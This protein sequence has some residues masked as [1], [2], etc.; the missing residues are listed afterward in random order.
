M[1]LT[2]YLSVRNRNLWL[3]AIL[4][5]EI[6]CHALH[7]QNQASSPL[8]SAP[9]L[10]QHPLAELIRTQPGEADEYKLGAGD[11]I[12]VS[13][14]GRPEL[15]GPHIVGLDGR[16]TMPTAGAVLVGG[17][18]RDEGARAITDLLRQYYVEPAVALQVTKYG[19]NFVAII[20]DITHP[21]KYSFNGPPTL[22]EAIALGGPLIGSDKA[23]RMPT[24]CTIYRGT[25]T[26]GPLNLSDITQDVRLQRNDII[27]VPGD[28]K[29]LISVL[30]EVKN[31]GRLPLHQESTLISLITDAGGITR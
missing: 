23:Q 18:T 13:V 3:G 11:E 30:G 6:F 12:S 26:I 2:V 16:I 31:P 8:D 29:R 21:G 14:I 7:A 4:S 28:L 5:L 20:G 22:L 27:Y 19:A 10:Q 17:R 1:V 15:S 25:S 24:S 9:A